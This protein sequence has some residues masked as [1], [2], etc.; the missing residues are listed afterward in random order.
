MQEMVTHTHTYTCTHTNLRVVIYLDT[1]TFM[2]RTALTSNLGQIKSLFRKIIWS[3]RRIS[4]SF[5]II[6]TSNG[7]VKKI[8]KQIKRAKY[9]ILMYRL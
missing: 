4:Q 2:S 3:T 8:G 7:K 5:G 1:E 9:Y 6:C